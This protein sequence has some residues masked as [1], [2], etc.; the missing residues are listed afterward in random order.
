M[1]LRYSLKI[2]RLSHKY[3]SHLIKW[4]DNQRKW[5]RMVVVQATQENS[6]KVVEI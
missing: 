4:Q 3:Q 2:W 5:G 6:E 1:Q